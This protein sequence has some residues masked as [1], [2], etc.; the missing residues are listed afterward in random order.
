MMSPVKKCVEMLL[1]LG[2][3]CWIV[4]PGA[5]AEP[6]ASTPSTAP[7]VEDFLAW[8]GDCSAA[9]GSAEGSAEAPARFDAAGCTAS[10]NCVHGT[11]ISCSSPLVGTCISSGAGCGQ[12]TCNGVTTFCPGRCRTDIHCLSFC[13]GEGVCD[14]FGCCDCG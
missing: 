7:S 4:V 3:V 10:Y 11:I 9:E 6:A 5:S 8:V 13:G 1:L 14:E 2:V 12:V